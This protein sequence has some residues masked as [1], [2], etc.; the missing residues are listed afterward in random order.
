MILNIKIRRVVKKLM[1]NKFESAKDNILYYFKMITLTRL[2]RMN[3]IVQ[4][5]NYSSVFIT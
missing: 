1:V 5:V 4:D 3:S 2:Y